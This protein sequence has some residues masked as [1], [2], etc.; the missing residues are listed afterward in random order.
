M[1]QQGSQLDTDQILHAQQ[2]TNYWKFKLGISTGFQHVE[3]TF[4]SLSQFSSL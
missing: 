4:F 3:K 2:L 1:I